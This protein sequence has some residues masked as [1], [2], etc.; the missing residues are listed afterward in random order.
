[1]K[2]TIIAAIAQDGIIGNKGEIPWKRDLKDDL[3]DF[4]EKTIRQTVIMGRKTFESIIRDLG[5]PLS[6]RCNIVISRT[7]TLDTPGIIVA[8]SWNE[9]L[10]KAPEGKEIFVIGGRE[11][12]ELA[13]PVA[14][15]LSLSRVRERFEGDTYFPPYDKSEWEIRD[16]RHFCKSVDN[17]H[18]FTIEE[19]QR[20]PKRSFVDLV[21]ARDETQLALMEQ[22]ERDGVCPFCP[23][24]LQKYHPRPLQYQS[25]CTVTENMTPYDGARAHWLIINKRHVERFGELTPEEKADICIQITALEKK[26]GAPGLTILMRSGDTGYT[27]G[28]VAHFH[29]HI[30]AGGASKDLG[31]PLRVKIGYTIPS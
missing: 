6:N 14:D 30:I 13:L 7:L 1:M 28:S 18:I 4:V 9:A 10:A 23:E 26:I 25:L 29:L 27:G 15:Q 5:K 31:T 24:H 2:I 8:R 3:R 16:A 12:Y 21:H 17:K 22:I 11:V 20:K 19:Y